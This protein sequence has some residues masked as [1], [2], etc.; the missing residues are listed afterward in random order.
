MNIKLSKQDFFD[1][2]KIARGRLITAKNWNLTNQQVDKT[3]TNADIELLGVLGEYAVA[4]CFNLEKPDCCGY[5]DGVDL[6]FEDKSIEV[7]T[8][9]HDHGHLIF[10]SKDKFI[11]DFAILVAETDCKMKLKIIGVTSRQKF[12]DRCVDKDFGNGTVSAMSQTDLQQ[13]ET[14]WRYLIEKQYA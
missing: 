13:P 2:K 10:K 14:F 11:A 9:Y 6:W 1:A 4:L 12:L 7:K 8:T 5:D 3:R